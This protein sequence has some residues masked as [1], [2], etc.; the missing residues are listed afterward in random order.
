MATAQLLV[1]IKSHG[2]VFTLFRCVPAPKRLQRCVGVLKPIA[3]FTNTL[4]RQLTQHRC[5]ML[6]ARR[7][8][9][10][11][12]MAFG[13]LR[14]ETSCACFSSDNAWPPMIF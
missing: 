9:Q 8:G 11:I 7:N 13:G 2:F 4:Q 3:V 5:E 12:Q 14:E 6:I 10:L 1:G